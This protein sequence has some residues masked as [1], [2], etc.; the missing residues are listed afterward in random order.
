VDGTD[1]LLVYEVVAKAAERARAGLGPSLIESKFYR[2][3]AHGNAIT[4]PPVPT[5]FPEHEAIGVY[6]NKAEYRAAKDQDPIPRFR[7][8]LVS[9][10]A[11]GEELDQLENRA[12]SE[13]DA[14][15]EF[16]LASPFPEPEEAINYVYA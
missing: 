5:Q 12:R 3:S 2:L 1:P 9:Q 11:S 15:V 13:M 16:A 8:H 4:V 7:A 6:G 14:A 10:G